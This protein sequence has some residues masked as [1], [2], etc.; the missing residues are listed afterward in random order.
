M[1]ALISYLAGNILVEGIVQMIIEFHHKHF[2]WEEADKTI[3][4]EM[5]GFFYSLESPVVRYDGRTLPQYWL[6]F[7]K[8]V[9]TIH[10][11]TR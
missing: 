9:K 6:K 8:Q 11:N 4:E 2:N 3:N 7:L 5:R 1:E 10:N